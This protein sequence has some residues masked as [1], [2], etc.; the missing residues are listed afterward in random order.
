[1]TSRAVDVVNRLGVH[2]RAAA[3]SGQSAF[4]AAGRADGADSG[5]ASDM[6]MGVPDDAAA[7]PLGT[8]AT[9]TAITA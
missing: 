3:K 1:M 2:A 6:P 8:A 4:G 7:H 5:T 9:A